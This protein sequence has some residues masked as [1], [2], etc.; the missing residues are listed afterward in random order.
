MFRLLLVALM[1]LSV[2]GC[3]GTDKDA[4]AEANRANAV[5]PAQT[6]TPAQAASGGI[7]G[8]VLETMNAGGYSY[9]LVQ[10]ATG[11][12]W[13]AGPE[14]SVAVGDKV[15][16]GQGMLM[17]DFRSEKLDRTFAEIYFVGAIK[18][19]GAATET[20]MPAGHGGAPAAATD[21]DV[22]D[23]AKADGGYTIAEMYAL[24]AS[25][26]GR[27]FA[28][29]GKV[30]KVNKN[31]MGTNWYHIQDGSEEG[32]HGDLTITSAA[33]LNVGDLVLVKGTGTV[34]KD[35]GAGYRYDLIIE[36]AQ[37]SVESI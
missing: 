13:A 20:A 35:F 31:I 28:V 4:V 5:P 14:T 8:E 15:D 10:T 36:D 7:V 12:V 32:V 18:P 2:V 22:S 29:R 33:A 30:V 1:L 34:N 6:A 37:I 9:V 26:S 25:A 21:I 16:L 11:D 19:A 23:V 3:N 24:G 17:P 27:E